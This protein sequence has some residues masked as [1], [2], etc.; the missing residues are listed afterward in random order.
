[1]NSPMMTPITARGMAIFMPLKIA[2]SANGKRTK[3]KL[4]QSEAVSERQRRKVDGSA[5]DNPMNDAMTTEK[6]QV[7]VEKAMRD[8]L[9]M[10]SQTTKSGASATFGTSW[11]A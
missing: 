11:N 4:C 10:P 6:K 3:R 9:V 5:L 1:M 7:N 8:S 2:G